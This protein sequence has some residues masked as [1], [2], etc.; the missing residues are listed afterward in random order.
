MTN[1]TFNAYD[2]YKIGDTFH[3]ENGDDYTIVALNKEDNK[4]LLVRLAE[5]G[6]P[7]YVGAKGLEKHSWW[8]GH[9]FM[10]NFAEA[11]KW[12]TQDE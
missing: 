11:S 9:Y 4:A 12:Y 10:E 8:H 5:D 2:F 7:F 1:N 6:T 3:N